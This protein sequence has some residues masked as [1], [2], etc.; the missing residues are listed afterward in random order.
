MPSPAQNVCIEHGRLRTEDERTASGTCCSSGG[1]SCDFCTCTCSCCHTAWLC[2]AG[3]CC[4]H[5]KWQTIKMLNILNAPLQH[6]SIQGV[7]QQ[8]KTTRNPFNSCEKVKHRGAFQELHQCNSS[9]EI[10][11]RMNVTG[12]TSLA[13]SESI[14]K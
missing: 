8:N 5:Q 9:G 7:S 4:L 14:Y 13:R 3:L 6:R 2:W 12:K 11:Q 1:I 10:F